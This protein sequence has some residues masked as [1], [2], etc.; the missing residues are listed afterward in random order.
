M[1][2]FFPNHVKVKEITSSEKHQEKN[3]YRK[4]AITNKSKKLL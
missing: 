4:A 1:Q 2:P 3:T